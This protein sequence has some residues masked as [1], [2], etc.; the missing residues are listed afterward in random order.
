QRVNINSWD[1]MLDMNVVISMDI[2]SQ[3]HYSSRIYLS[4]TNKI[5]IIFKIL[6]HIIV[7]IFYLQI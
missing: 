1:N 3:L 7:E 5:F 2:S 6:L 4:K